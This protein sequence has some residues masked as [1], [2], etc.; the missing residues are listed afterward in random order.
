[1]SLAAMSL[2]GAIYSAT[3]LAHH[4]FAAEFDRHKPVILKGTITKVEWQNPHTRLYLSVPNELGMISNWELELS[5]PNSLLRAGWTRHSVQV[6]DKITVNGFRA[7]DGSSL[8]NA[9]TM[10]AADGR[11]ILSQQTSPDAPAPK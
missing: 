8:A 5:S 7:K 1:M 2:A 11:R 9:S 10:F 4:S 3:A 6:G